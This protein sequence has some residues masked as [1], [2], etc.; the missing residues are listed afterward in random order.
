MN[1]HL[2]I[3][4]NDRGFINKPAQ[5][6]E[7]APTLRAQDHGNQPKVIEIIDDTY[8]FDDEMRTYSE[9]CPTL[10][11]SRQGLKVLEET[12]GNEM[13]NEQ[14]GIIVMGTLDKGGTTQEHNNRV[15]D[16][17]GISP[18]LTAVS[19]G[20][21]HIKIFDVSKF[22][23][24]KLTPTEYGRLQ[25]FPVDD[26][27]EQVVSDSQA[28]KQF[29]NAVT[30]TVV[31]A[32]GNSIKAFLDPHF[33]KDEPEEVTDLSDAP[34]EIKKKIIENAELL[35]ERDEQTEGPGPEA[36]PKENT[37]ATFS[38]DELL[39]ELNRRMAANH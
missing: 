27:W 21:H 15:H 2:D 35:E 10:R 32:I 23:V 31:T 25:A 6:T 18:T 29:G 19:G 12:G 36:A 13:A 4:V 11:A 24:R 5:I 37:L 17:D 39:A 33:L 30:T 22:R 7:I 14:P 8:G 16:T 34:A 3:C 9:I 1:K 20:T 28:Y 38:N 26:G